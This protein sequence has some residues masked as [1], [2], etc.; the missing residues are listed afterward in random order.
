M[1]CFGFISS[2]CGVW[3]FLIWMIQNA[4]LLLKWKGLYKNWLQILLSHLS[5][6]SGTRKTET[7]SRLDQK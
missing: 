6:K 4:T 3:L 5:D 2:L 1:V 7:T